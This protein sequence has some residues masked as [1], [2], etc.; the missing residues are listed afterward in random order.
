LVGLVMVSMIM[1]GFVS[2]LIGVVNLRRGMEEEVET[3]VK[4]ACQSYAMVLDYTR[5]STDSELAS[6]ENDMSEKTGYDYTFFSGD[7]RKRSSIAGAVGTKASDVVID[8]VI[9]K[10]QS[11]LDKNIV[12]NGEK[13]YV[14]Y[15]PLIDSATNEVYG[16]AFVGMKKVEISSYINDR[17]KIMVTLAALIVIVCTIAAVF[18]V[19]H[20]VEAIGESVGAVR[21]MAT[22]DLNIS[23]TEKVRNRKDELGEMAVALFD[24]CSKIR[25]VI[26]NA[27]TSAV[28]VDSSSGYLYS[29]AREI[30]GT[31]ES[32]TNSVS[33]V[34]QGA[35]DQAEALQEAVVSVNEINEAI[36]LI[37]ENT[38][39]MNGIADSMQTNSKTSQEKLTE[40][41]ASTKESIGAID[42]IV[43][44]IGNTNGAVTTISK[45]VEII[46]DIASQT[47]LLSLNAS[48]EAARAGEAGR[49]FAVVADEIRQLADQSAEAARNIQE[50]MNGLAQDSNK[51]M[52]SAGSVQEAMSIQ[53]STIHSTIEQ[54]DALIEEINKSI[55]L[56]GQIVENVERSEK[57]RNIISDTITSLSSISEENAASSEA[58]KASMDDLLKTMDDLSN[59]AGA[60]SDVAKVLDEEIGFFK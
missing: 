36:S 57:A 5:S 16:M 50:A 37:I 21:L 19:L 46:H 25:Q 45:A 35:C 29:T 11:F 31:A 18:Y 47:N 27:R 43:E 24:M 14:A 9:K 23:I 51:T 8:A 39:A 40:L 44:L 20:I 48:I 12:I 7:T 55:S 4:A 2:T 10:R 33:Q 59:K 38:Q 34:A 30:T 41:R 26:G 6:L 3:G 53:G 15:E 54:V 17:I 56:T 60:L 28:E 49:G 32:V 13:Y 1:V 58:T 22:G 42:E 52:Q